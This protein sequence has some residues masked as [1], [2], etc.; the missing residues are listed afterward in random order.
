MSPEIV[1]CNLA[2]K[3][4][5]T[6]LESLRAL[7]Q[8]PLTLWQTTK[9]RL[10]YLDTILYTGIEKLVDQY[11][12]D[13]KQFTVID[14]TYNSS[15]KPRLCVIIFACKHI[16]DCILEL[17]AFGLNDLPSSTKTAIKN[18]YATCEQYICNLKFR[19]ILDGYF[20]KVLTDIITALNAL[21]NQLLTAIDIEGYLASYLALLN[22]TTITLTGCNGNTYTLLGYFEYL[23]DL[24]S[25][26]NQLCQECGIVVDSQ[27]LTGFGRKL[28]LAQQANGSWAIVLDSQLSTFQSRVDG[29]VERINSLISIAQGGRNSRLDT[30]PKDELLY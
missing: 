25:E 24:A 11:E 26:A 15:S 20:S 22:S 14:N 21:K 23:S 29:L 28:S 6:E 16:L 19:Q 13:I 2:S 8:A 27:E 30:I 5:Q 1:F 18:D 17:P 12:N 10:D 3:K 9:S 7:M 4:Y